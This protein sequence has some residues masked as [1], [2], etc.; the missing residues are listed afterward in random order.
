MAGKAI[1]IEETSLVARYFNN[2]HPVRIFN[3]HFLSGIAEF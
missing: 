1:G 3:A 2:I